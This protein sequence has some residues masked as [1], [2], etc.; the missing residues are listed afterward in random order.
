MNET[1]KNEKHIRNK[2]SDSF[3]SFNRKCQQ[4]GYRARMAIDGTNPQKGADMHP[5]G[6]LADFRFAI[7][8]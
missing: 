1:N 4:I 5:W 6:E 3:H 7:F 2:L 8:F